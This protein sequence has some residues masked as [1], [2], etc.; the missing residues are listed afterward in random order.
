MKKTSLACLKPR[1][2]QSLFL[3]A[4]LCLLAV[5]LP[6][7]AQTPPPADAGSIL[8]TPETARPVPPA[9]QQE[10]IPLLREE[11]PASGI[12]EET[13]TLLVNRFQVNHP[14]PLEAA[15]VEATLAPFAGKRLTVA[16]I[17]AAAETLAARYHARGFYLARVWLPP[18]DARD[19]ILTLEVSPGRYGKITVENHAPVRDAW[20]Q[21]FF[22]RLVPGEIANTAALERALLLV[23]GLPGQ[24]LPAVSL[25]PGETDG[26]SD[27][28]FVVNPGKRLNAYATLDNQGS[29]YTGRNRLGLGVDLNSPF[30]LGDQ[31]SA[32]GVFTRGESRLH[33]GRLAYNLPLGTDGLRL[34]AALDHTT[35]TL[36]DQYAPLEA[37]GRAQSVELGLR[38]PLIRS[39]NRN[40]EISA[41]A[42]TRRLRD[43]ME[44]FDYVMKK[45]LRFAR[46][47]AHYDQWA[48]PGGRALYSAVDLGYTEGRL[49][50]DDP[51]QRAAN[52]LGIQSE[53]RYRK[54]ALNVAF[55][56]ALT[57]KLSLNATL[58]AQRALGKSL[59]GSE[60]LTIS[61]PA[62]AR[63]YRETLSGDHGFMGNLE[64]RYLLPGAGGMSHS[65]GIFT[66]YGKVSYERPDYAVDNHIRIQDAGLAWQAFRAPFFLRAQLAGKIGSEPRPE[67]MK[68]DGKTHLL[69]QLGVMY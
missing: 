1:C 61:G 65:V 6:A 69:L 60:Q 48:S 55:H 3:V 63:A 17:E 39:Q 43:E 49:S 68:R 34:D 16:E 42:V 31:L 57:P 40:L 18:Q 19:G 15:E 23:S 30:R 52:R 2:L 13:E 35:Y 66:G 7:A 14:E 21:G 33:N 45:R 62:G 4:P 54:L 27:L 44:A 38:Y 67:V 37:T 41:R 10:S 12:P 46:F 29:R 11:T 50:F 24:E 26:T 8:H 58:A 53:G 56:Y 59:D 64:L 25:T 32:S 28:R 20:M 9:P 5:F 22:S 51:E 36:G 47:N